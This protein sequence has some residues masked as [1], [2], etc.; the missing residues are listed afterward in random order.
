M[1]KGKIRTPILAR[2]RRVSWVAVMGHHLR[3]NHGG[4]IAFKNFVTKLGLENSAT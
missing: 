1:T 2:V 3:Q 4:M